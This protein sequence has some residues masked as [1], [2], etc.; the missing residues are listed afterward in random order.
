MACKR[1]GVQIPLAPRETA[2]QSVFTHHVVG[3][4]TRLLQPL[5]QADGPIVTPGTRSRPAQG[6]PRRRARSAWPGLITPHGRRIR[7]AKC[8]FKPGTLGSNALRT[9]TSG[10]VEAIRASSVRSNRA[11]ALKSPNPPRPLERVQDVNRCDSDLS[12]SAPLVQVGTLN[13]TCDAGAPTRPST[14]DETAIDDD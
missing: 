7:P 1:S 8:S 2:G 5:V 12:P 13:Q 4:T 6:C 3:V 9:R 11:R 14:H 10:H